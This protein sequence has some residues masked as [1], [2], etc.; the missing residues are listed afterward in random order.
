MA[1]GK[2][3]GQSLA[4]IDK[5]R[6]IGAALSVGMRIASA[7]FADRGFRYW[8]W[9]GNCGSGKNAAFNTPGS[10]VVFWQ[11][12]E[13]CLRGLRPAAFFCDID[14]DAMR[15]LHAT[16]KQN[17]DWAARSYLLPGDNQDALEVFA[18]CIRKHENPRFAVGSVLVDPNGYYYRN[19]QGIGAPIHALQWFCREFPRIDI[20]LNLNVRAYQLQAKSGH[21][22]L[23][24]RDVLISLNKSHWLVSRN[25][26]NKGDRFL[27]AIGRNT[28]TKEMRTLQLYDQHS[29]LGKFILNWA[30]GKNQ[31]EMYDV[32][33]LPRVPTARGI[34]RGS[35][36]GDTPSADL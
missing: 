13:I 14:R 21:R 29:E 24:P 3:Q 17:S 33:Q 12:S 35:R 1:G 26:K 4:T 23:P 15:Q 2:Q 11:V 20:I 8:H 30:E 16:L 10:P 34:P 19:A 9:D 31:Q 5:E 28:P 6:R 18:E 25:A 36:S 27:L 22:V 32:P 7:K